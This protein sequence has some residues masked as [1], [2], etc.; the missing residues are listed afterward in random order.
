MEDEIFEQ[1]TDL[2]RLSAAVEQIKATIGKII[3]GQADV[4]ELL[5]TGILADGH[6]LIEGETKSGT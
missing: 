1:R 5:I 3:V 2:T 4:I 6:I